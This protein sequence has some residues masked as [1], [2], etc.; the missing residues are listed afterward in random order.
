MIPRITFLT[1]VSINFFG[2]VKNLVAGQI[3]QNLNSLLNHTI[4][5]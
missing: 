4:N 5:T 1:Y 2:A 3:L